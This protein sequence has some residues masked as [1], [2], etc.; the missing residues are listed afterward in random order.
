VSVKRLLLGTRGSPLA[1]WQ[2]RAVEARLG[3]VGVLVETIVLRPSG[4]EDVSRPISELPSPA[5]FAD[6]IEAALRTGTIDIAVHS[7]KDLDPQGS[8]G[9][10][11][12]AVPERGVSTESLVSRSG[13]RIRD[14]PPNARVGTSCARR[15]AQIR[16][17][18]GDLVP[19][20]I[21]GAVDQRV[22][23]VRAGRFD[24]A[25]LATV[26]L[27]RLG[28]E[29]EIAQ[30]FS[31]E[32]LTPAAGQGAL[33]VQTRADDSEVRERVARLDDPRLRSATSAEL[34]LQATF[35]PGTPFEVAAVAEWNAE[36]LVLFAKLVRAD[37]AE[38]FSARVAGKTA[39]EASFTAA[40]RLRHLAA[41]R[42][43]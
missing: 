35:E 10:V 6:E 40:L 1:L 26:G 32:D 39:S 16:M 33:A 15:A 7:L 18:R 19:V 9:L 11:V 20:P 21:R 13:C 12:A 37:G 17:L 14:L 38:A 41:E 22:R 28:L 24:A 27:A 8:P 3:A 30:T 43:A 5:P 31:I 34:Q 4:D 29:R 36:E 2:A 42:A 25:V 23:Q